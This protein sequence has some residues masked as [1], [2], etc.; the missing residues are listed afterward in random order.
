MTDPPTHSDLEDRLRSHYK[1][2]AGRVHPRP[3]ELD[4]VLR[5]AERATDGTRQSRQQPVEGL[6]PMIVERQIETA[7]RW[8]RRHLITASAVAAAVVGIAVGGLV[9]V[10]RQ[11]DPTREVAAAP[12]NPPAVDAGPTTH[13]WTAS[14]P[15]RWS[16]AS[17]ASSA[18]APVTTSTRHT[19]RTAMTW[20]TFPSRLMAPSGS[21]PHTTATDRDANDPGL[22][23]LLWALGSLG[24]PSSPTFY[25]SLR[26]QRR[27]LACPAS[28]LPEE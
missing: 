24:C 6:A 18:T 16:Q 15:R 3:L 27:A 2:D 25:A 10:T 9:I 20:S 21:G 22:H 23:E 4:E 1:V 14:S 7:R 17:N 5:L 13:N 28:T 12:L 19:R 11:D 8:P 26:R